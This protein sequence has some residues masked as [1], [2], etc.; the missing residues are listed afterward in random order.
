MAPRGVHKHVF[1][2][3]SGAA[4]GCAQEDAIFRAMEQIGPCF[5]DLLCW[6][7]G[8]C[9]HN[10]CLL[11]PVGSGELRIFPMELTLTVRHAL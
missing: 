9:C 2:V 3:P 4:A 11:C 8:L 6:H 5:L 7:Q 1:C 10:D